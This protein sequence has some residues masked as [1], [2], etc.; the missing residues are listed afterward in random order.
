MAQLERRVITPDDSSATV[1]TQLDLE[2]TELGT[3]DLIIDHQDSCPRL[4]ICTCYRHDD[5]TPHCLIS[6]A[7]VNVPREYY[8]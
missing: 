4:K 8:L 2:G 7:R 1:T 3:A 6:K 5:Q